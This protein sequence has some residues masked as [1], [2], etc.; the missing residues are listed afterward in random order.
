MAAIPIS[1]ALLHST[2]P[3]S[4]WAITPKAEVKMIPASEVAVAT[5][6]S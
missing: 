6:A 5:L 2:L 4:P 3:S 1:R